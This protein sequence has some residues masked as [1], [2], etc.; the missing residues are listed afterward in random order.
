VIGPR[1][2]PVRADGIVFDL[3]GTL[4][5]PNAT[6]A[7]AWNRVLARLGIDRDRLTEAD[8]RR[9]AG[10]THREA[11]GL[12]LAELDDALLDRI[13]EA[14]EHEDNL[15]L[16]AGGGELF[17]GVR[18]WIPHLAERFPLMI[19][20]NCQAGY[21]EV[22]R[23]NS[24]LDSYFDDHQCWGDSGL[25]K[26]ENLSAVISRNQLE[27]PVFVGD[28]AGDRAAAHDNG[29]PFVHAAYGFGTVEDCDAAIARF[30]DLP[31]LLERA[32]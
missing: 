7:R 10:H 28:T 27:R 16:E 8:I 25:S 5:D 30:S 9:V 14:T 32:R 20:S 31:S 17:D 1:A 3:D 21:I 18:E 26:S 29:T 22:F 24:G 2:A 23:R 11:V 15:A 13:S 4:W 12:V 19:V 6:C